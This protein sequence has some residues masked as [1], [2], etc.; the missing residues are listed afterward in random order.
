[1]VIGIEDY[2]RFADGEDRRRKWLEF[3]ALSAE[4][5]A[6]GDVE[7]ELPARTTRP[8]PFANRRR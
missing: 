8:D 5:R 7:L 2:R 4:L 6:D 3:L 1:M